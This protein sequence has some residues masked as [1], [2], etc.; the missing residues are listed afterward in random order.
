MS[1]IQVSLSGHCGFELGLER[2]GRVRICRGG[3]GHGQ[4]KRQPKK[5]YKGGNRKKVFN[6]EQVIW[7]ICRVELEAR[8][9]W[10]VDVREKKC[11]LSLEHKLCYF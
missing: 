11:I 10:S 9:H 8:I 7:Q 1:D 4:Q 2:C 6:E 3:G 5:R